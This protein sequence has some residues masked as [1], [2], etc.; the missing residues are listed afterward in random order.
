[1]PH[2]VRVEDLDYNID[3]DFYRTWPPSPGSGGDFPSM[4][5]TELRESFDKLHEVAGIACKGRTSE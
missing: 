5:L 3:G 4:A 2:L 1:V